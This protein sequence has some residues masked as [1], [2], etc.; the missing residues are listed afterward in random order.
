MLTKGLLLAV[1]ANSLLHRAYHAYPLSLT[2][3]DGQPVNAV[4]G[5]T[6]MFLDALLQFKPEYVFCAFD[7]KKPTFR[8][9]SY[10]GYKAN[11]PVA[12]NELVTQIPYVYEVLK[13]LNIPV[14]DV[15]GYEADDILGTVATKIGTER[16]WPITQTYILTGDRDL[17]QLVNERV[18]V[19][20]PKGSFKNLEQFTEDKV[21]KSMGVTPERVPDLK[22]LMGDSSDNIPGVKGIG[23]KSASEL[24]N[25]YQTI[26]EIYTHIGDIAA[27]NKRIAQLLT[28]GHESAV[29]SKQLATIAKDAPVTFVP[30]DAETRTF[31]PR[32]VSQLFSKMQFKSLFPRLNKLV[33]LAGNSL[34][35]QNTE[36]LEMNTEK[37]EELVEQTKELGESNE[38]IHTEIDL[39]NK[40]FGDRVEL[41]FAKPK[42]GYW[43][44][45]IYC[46]EVL[47]ISEFP[48][49]NEA[50]KKLNTISFGMFDMLSNAASATEQVALEEKNLK[51]LL[52]I[53]L[54]SYL[55]HTG[56]SDYSLQQDLL[57]AGLGNLPDELKN[58]REKVVEITLFRMASEFATAQKYVPEERVLELWSR[59]TDVPEWGGLIPYTIAMCEDLPAAIG[60]ALMHQR[61]ISIDLEKVAEKIE[62]YK[63]IITRCEKEIY[64]IVG[65]EFNIRSPKQLANVL[66]GSLN[67]PNARKTKTGYSTDDEVLQGLVSAHPV[68]EKI[69]EF[70]QISKLVSTYME[71]Y[72]EL[73]KRAET[74]NESESEGR[75]E[76]M[77]M[78]AESK[79]TGTSSQHRSQL[80]LNGNLLRVHSTFSVMST[81]SGRLSSVNPNLQNLP[82]KTEAGKVIRSF[83]VPE[84]GK[85][86]VS[87]D[88]SQIDLRVLAHISRDQ[89]LIDAFR[90]GD[91]IHRSTAAKV[92]H[93]PFNK[94]TDS[95]RR[96]SK[97]INF[98]LVYGMSSFGLAKSIGVDVK[99][100]AKF[101][102]EYF[103]QFP[104][105]KEYMSKT[106]VFAR[107]KGYVQS[108]LGRRR[109]IG[110]INTS[111]KMRAQASERE[112][113]NMP[114][115][116][117]AD[118]IMRLAL[119][120]ITLLPEILSGEIKLVLQVHDELVFEMENKSK[121]YLDEKI[122]KIIGIME[123]VVVLDVP[124]KA[125]AEIGESLSM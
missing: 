96:F 38:A 124:L 93:T 108:L 10:T 110:G 49:K 114:I 106:V 92:F 120:K 7:T 125:E 79:K 68:V 105:V 48:R 70:R 117:G 73:K 9:V 85:K 121:E 14:F 57:Q 58:N 35:Q 2:T 90:K 27:D 17:F 74:P 62:E 87:I 51:D 115:Q 76:Q 42:E 43:K 103:A 104:Q 30:E 118:D 15:E 81:S 109:F 41:L 4:Y 37:S 21:F 111:N 89:G 56:R 45:A 20:L 83:F 54:L 32:E 52:D 66:F 1:D 113:I 29:M 75:G 63:N 64:D 116:G 19:I 5:F 23:P 119:G 46:N 82:V 44:L 65:F 34:E 13:T 11:R 3:T 53:E 98:G 22:G 55:L 28:D 112:A 72:L 95:Q 39:L 59:V 69:M 102:E 24:L 122:A 8:H 33:A 84:K 36:Q 12:D 80:E 71:P 91:D 88:Y 107:E 18:Q 94:V 123:S 40:D 97:S 86:L 78:F 99:E 26:E 6:A 61:G 16:F 47:Y 77:S 25:K 101:I 50:N 60:V 100:A 67:L 31:N